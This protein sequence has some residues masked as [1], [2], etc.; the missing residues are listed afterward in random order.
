MTELLQKLLN[1]RDVAL[2][3]YQKWALCSCGEKFDEY[4]EA[5]NHL[6]IKHQRRKPTVIEYKQASILKSCNDHIRNPSTTV[7]L[8]QKTK[9]PILQDISAT[10]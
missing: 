6:V 5:E 10:R 2:L 7:P 9:A 3:L 1:D 4:T 8:S